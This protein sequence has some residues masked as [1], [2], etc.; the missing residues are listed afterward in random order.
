M[1]SDEDQDEDEESDL[2]GDLKQL[3]HHH[4]PTNLLQALPE[5]VAKHSAFSSRPIDDKGWA[6]VSRKHKLRQVLLQTP[7][8]S[9]NSWEGRQQR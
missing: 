4:R 9:K 5:L 6:E 3:V 1:E 8:S 2:F 7:S